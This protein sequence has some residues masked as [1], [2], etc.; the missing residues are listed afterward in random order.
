MFYEGVVMKKLLISSILIAAS[1]SFVAH[2]ESEKPDRVN[3]EWEDPKSYTD[4]RPSNQSRKRFREST[5]N[6]IEKH[7]EKLALKLPDGQTLKMTVT[8]LD[9]AGHVWPGH[10][11]GLDSTSE[12]RIIKRIDIPRVDFSYQLMDASGAVLKEGEEK[13]KDMNFQEHGT[14][15]FSDDALRYEKN[16]L[17][18]WFKNTFELKQKK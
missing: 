9:L 10:I 2:A 13:L 6:R 3:I 17:T 15:R 16:M 18:D 7:L 8:D 5:F 12:V 1:S 11:A 4:V 14:N